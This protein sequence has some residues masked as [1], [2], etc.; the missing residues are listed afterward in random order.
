MWMYNV[1]N[2]QWQ[3]LIDSLIKE[4]ICMCFYYQQVQSSHLSHLFNW[5][6][7]NCLQEN[8]AQSEEK[9]GNHFHDMNT[10]AKT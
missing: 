1:L 2:V 3:S 4:K 6:D 5:P 10:T 9:L 7:I 8:G